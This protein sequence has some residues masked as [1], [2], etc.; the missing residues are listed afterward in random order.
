VKELQIVKVILDKEE[1]RGLRLIKV[2]WLLKNAS[3]QWIK[4]NRIF[5]SGLV[6]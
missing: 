1:W 5:L 4:D 2:Y 3:G 6:N